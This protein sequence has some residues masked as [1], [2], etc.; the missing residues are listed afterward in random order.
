MSVVDMGIWRSVCHDQFQT[1]ASCGSGFPAQFGDAPR[2]LTGLETPVAHRRDSIHDGACSRW[3]AHHWV[4]CA[5][6]QRHRYWPPP[7]IFLG[8]KQPPRFPS[9]IGVKA[10]FLSRAS[11]W[12]L[13]VLCDAS[14]T[15]NSNEAFGKGVKAVMAIANIVR[16]SLGPTGLD[17]MLV[18]RAVFGPTAG[19]GSEDNTS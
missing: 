19:L 4:R 18:S 14:K 5:H 13:F 15:C 11:S 1:G 12:L 16:S 2:L 9:E 17:K 3:A 7:E 10:S 6:L 8:K